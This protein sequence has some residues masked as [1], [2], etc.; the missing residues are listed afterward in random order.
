M[1]LSRMPLWITLKGRVRSYLL[2]D[3]DKD[4]ECSS[5][6]SCAFS[7]L[8]FM[9]SRLS[10]LQSCS[11]DPG[12]KHGSL[13]RGGFFKHLPPGGSAVALCD[14]IPEVLLGA[15]TCFVFVYLHMFH[16]GKNLG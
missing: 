11:W 2:T 10:Y 16:T 6:A 3:P 14:C 4:P 5:K 9:Q 15:V 13:E 7:A 1:L 12:R 8:V